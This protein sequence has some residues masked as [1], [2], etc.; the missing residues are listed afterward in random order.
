MAVLTFT[1]RERPVEL[2]EAYPEC[3]GQAPLALHYRRLGITSVCCRNPACER[4]E[5]KGGVLAD[6]VDIAAK[7]ERAI[8][9]GRQFH[10]GP[11]S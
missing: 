7:W 8:V 1:S 9:E 2:S 10:Q 5:S 6:D 11:N 4:H 3:C